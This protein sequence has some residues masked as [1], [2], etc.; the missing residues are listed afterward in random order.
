VAS[1]AAKSVIS[2]AVF[3]PHS[4]QTSSF[5]SLCDTIQTIGVGK[6]T[7]ERP[8][9][10]CS[11]RSGVCLKYFQAESLV[12]GSKSYRIY[13]VCASC[14]VVFMVW[15]LGASMVSRRELLQEFLSV[16]LLI[17]FA[18]VATEFSIRLSCEFGSS[19]D[20]PNKEGTC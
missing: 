18:L 14:P 13:G 2:L 3:S 12:G 16:E 20:E 1:R 10:A 19:T 9:A 7:N 11:R 8:R 5:L 4:R 15:E 6:R 17:F